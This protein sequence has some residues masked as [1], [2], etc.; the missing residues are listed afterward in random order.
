[1]PHEAYS[2][3]SIDTIH[4]GVP[5]GSVPSSAGAIRSVDR[6]ASA[7]GKGAESDLSGSV[8]RQLVGRGGE[9]AEGSAGDC[10]RLRGQGRV[11]HE[12]HAAIAGA[13]VGRRGVAAHLPMGEPAVHW[14]T[15]HWIAGI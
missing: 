14:V 3:R 11:Q 6:E 5:G 9:T 1:M 2:P 4:A 10:A 8:D 12:H 13:A 15:Y 7:S